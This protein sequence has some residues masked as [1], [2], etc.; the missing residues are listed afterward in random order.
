M[1]SRAN[2]FRYV[3]A[4]SFGLR[5]AGTEV[6]IQF[7]II[8]D[9]SKPQ[10]SQQEQVAIVTSLVGAKTLGAILNEAIRSYEAETNTIVPTPNLEELFGRAQRGVTPKS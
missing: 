6:V 7:G 5:L 8:E 9:P 4:N 2:D 10:D 1:A 3:Y